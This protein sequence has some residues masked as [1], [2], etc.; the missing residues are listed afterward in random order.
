MTV[1]DLARPAKVATK[2]VVRF[3]CGEALKAS[4][5]EMIQIALEKAAVIFV[6]ANDGGPGV[7]LRQG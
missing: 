6:D 3:E 1:S 2:T 7:R 5:V 4:T